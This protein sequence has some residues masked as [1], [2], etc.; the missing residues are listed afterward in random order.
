[1]DAKLPIGGY[2]VSEEL[3]QVG[4]TAADGHTLIHVMERLARRHVNLAYVTMAADHAGQTD[5]TCACG[6]SADAWPEAKPLLSPLHRTEKNPDEGLRIDLVHGVGTL[7]VF[8][9]KS[10]LVLLESI[11]GAFAQAGLPV[12]SVASS[13]SALTFATDYGRLDT[14]ARILLETADLPSNPIPA[15][16]Q[17]RVE[18]I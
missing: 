9:H 7:T 16:P 11:L 6:I 18:Q 1:M 4:M 3:I 5:W 13:L 10:R 17:W 2:K 12:H 15:R 14:A 8:P